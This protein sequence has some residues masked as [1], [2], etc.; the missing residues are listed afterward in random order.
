MSLSKEQMA[1]LKALADADDPYNTGADDAHPEL[2]LR[3]DE[4]PAVVKWAGLG[5][6]VLFVSWIIAAIVSV[7]L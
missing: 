5:I 7:L 3:G 2:V 6:A 1:R 4:I